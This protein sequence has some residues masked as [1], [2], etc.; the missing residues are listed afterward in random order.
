MSILQLDDIT[1]QRTAGTGEGVESADSP[2][3]DQCALRPVDELI[4][5]ERGFTQVSDSKE[6]ETLIKSVLSDQEANVEAYK[7]GNNKVFGFLVGQILKASGGKA[8]PVLVN[9]ILTQLLKS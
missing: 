9:Q 2:F 6:I 7:N 3:N 8:N 5:Q 4:V 1:T